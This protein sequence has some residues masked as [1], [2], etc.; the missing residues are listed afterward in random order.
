M[1]DCF[2]CGLVIGTWV[3]I[4]QL[5][6]TTGAPL[7]PNDVLVIESIKPKGAYYEAEVPDTLDLARRAEFSVNVLTHN[8]N[9]DKYYATIDLN[10][11]PGKLEV[12][13]GGNWDILCK[14]VRALPM[15]RT[16]SGSRLNL[17][18][19]IEM[20]RAM[21]DQTGEDGQI[22]YPDH[23]F[24]HPKNTSLP[25]FNGLAML[26]MQLWYERDGN[27]AWRDWIALVC[28]GLKE[29]AIEVEDRA[30]FPP[31]CS[32][33][34]DGSWNWTLRHE[35]AFPYKPP[36]EPSFDQQGYEGSVKFEESQ[37]YRA[38][39]KYYEMSGDERAMEVARKVGRFVMK[40][41]MWEDTSE[42]GYPGH[43]HGIWAGHVHGNITNLHAM[44]DLA[45][46][47]DDARLKQIVREGYDHAVRNGI[48]RMG[49]FPS[50]TLPEKYRRHAPYHSVDETCGM[51]DIV[52]L[53]AK[54][55]D[56]GLGD[57]WDDVDAIVRN[58]LGTHQMVDLDLMRRAA[59]VG[60][61]HD[62][63]L[64]RYMGSFNQ[65]YKTYTNAASGTCCTA[66]GAIGLYYAWHGITRFDGGV[67]TVNMFLNRASD[68]MDIDSYLPYEGKVVL[69]NKKAR[70]ALVRVPSWIRPET[71]TC[72]VDG[73][74]VRPTRV[75]RRLMITNLT[76]NSKITLEFPLQETIDKYLIFDEEKDGKNVPPKEYTL[77]F[78][79]STIIDI[80]PRTTQTGVYL[81]YQRDH[82]KGTQAP[83]RN[84]TRFAPENTLPLQ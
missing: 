81:L 23:D 17:D 53:A 80:S 47:E 40:P 62:E 79:G 31:E 50:W 14:N 35:P 39:V 36:E 15:M 59:E 57:Y 52:V 45:V 74:P 26:A 5:S 65:G 72:S 56:A 48:V 6:S 43:E 42:D 16:M 69:H 7:D 75:G 13:K 12:S 55:T 51:A 60:P 8:V 11:R 25:W 46:A 64:K 49:W 63:V 32:R 19:E 18:V 3:L 33:N 22:Y 34:P 41:S 70:T 24:H 38:L 67:A 37:S 54:L 2:R 58:H 61:E 44:L 20:M 78:R 77:T 73:R 68:W 1:V 76:K 21:L 27:D 29:A 10:F 4:G 71:I 83:M 9:P 28:D 84:M 30:Y 66:N 82:L